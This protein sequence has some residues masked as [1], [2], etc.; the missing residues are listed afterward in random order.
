MP[1]KIPIYVD[2]IKSKEQ[3]RASLEKPWE[4]LD[5]TTMDDASKNIQVFLKLNTGEIKRI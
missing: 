3:A 1:D 5:V 4:W 2:F